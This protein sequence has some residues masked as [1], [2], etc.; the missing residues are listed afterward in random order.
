[1]KLTLY[2]IIGLLALPAMAIKIPKSFDW[3]M[4]LGGLSPIRNQNGCGSSWAFPIVTA[5]ETA[6]K[7]KEGRE[8]QLSA[9]QILSCSDAGNCKGGW[10]PQPYVVSTGLALEK[11]FPYVASDVSC[12]QNLSIFRKASGWG[13]VHTIDPKAVAPT[14]AIQE[15]VLKFGEITTGIVAD[16]K[17]NAYPG[18]VIECSQPNS[19]HPNHL[20]SIIGWTEEGAWIVRNSWGEKWGEKGYFRIQYGCNKIGTY[21]SYLTYETPDSGP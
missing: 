16:D 2:F 17:L 21:A 7:M 18:N 6:I 8:V 5:L 1:M 15:A 11:D 12:Q 4:Q 20:V 10:M 9:Q 19:N 14:Q 13:Y 3:R